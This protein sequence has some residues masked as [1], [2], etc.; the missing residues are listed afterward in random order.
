[1][2][3][4]VLTVLSARKRYDTFP[5]SPY[6]VI[7]HIFLLNDDF[8]FWIYYRIFQIMYMK[9]GAFA[10]NDLVIG[11]HALVVV[12]VILLKFRVLLERAKGHQRMM[13]RI[14]KCHAFSC[15]R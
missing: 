5:F 1:M 12:V 3:T 6:S 9:D 7:S 8:K 11:K 4:K 14:L 2:M 10:Y 15:I 13:N